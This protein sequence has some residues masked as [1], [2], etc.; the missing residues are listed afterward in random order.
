MVQVTDIH[1]LRGERRG[2]GITTTESES[3]SAIETWLYGWRCRQARRME[4]QG[5][6]QR[7]A[8]Q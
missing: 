1:D 3:V 2:S 8:S 7:G 6:C 5:C 4:L